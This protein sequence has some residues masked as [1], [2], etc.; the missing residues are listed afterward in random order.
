MIG[1]SGPK[2]PLLEEPVSA[3]TTL[4]T[5]EDPGSWLALPLFLDGPAMLGAVASAS[6]AALRPALPCLS[7][8][9]TV[10]ELSAPL[11]GPD[12]LVPPG[13]KA[14]LG[15]LPFAVGTS[16]RYWLTPEFP[17]GAIELPGEV[18]RAL[19]G[20]ASDTSSAITA[21]LIENSL[22]PRR[23]QADSSPDQ[24][25]GVNDAR[26]PGLAQAS[27]GLGRPRPSP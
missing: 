4:V 11:D 26:L 19:A 12:P 13:T 10:D 23:A 17:G 6:A 5:G 9:R 16:S 20:R 21:L 18:A 8:A 24:H 7:S 22:R 1:S 14:L 2:P 27:R 25:R 15:R 3:F